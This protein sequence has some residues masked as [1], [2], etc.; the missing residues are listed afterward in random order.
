MLYNI[1]GSEPQK[2]NVILSTYQSDLPPQNQ[3]D[4]TYVAGLSV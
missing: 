3:S 1:Q 2:I 4:V